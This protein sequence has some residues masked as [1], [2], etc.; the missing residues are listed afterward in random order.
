MGCSPLCPWGPIPVRMCRIGSTVPAKS[1]C[2]LATERQQEEGS[3]A[4]SWCVFSSILEKDK[5]ERSIAVTPRSIKAAMEVLNDREV[6]V[7]T[8]GS[9]R[10]A[11]RGKVLETIT[12]FAI[13]RPHRQVSRVAPACRSLLPSGVKSRAAVAF[14][15]QA[16]VTECY[17]C[18]ANNTHLPSPVLEAGT[19][20]PDV[21]RT[22]PPEASPLG[23]WTAI[24]CPCPRWPP[25]VCGSLCPDLLFPQGH[26]VYWI[27]AHLNGLI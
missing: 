8:G 22:G 11:F 21:G 19:Q 12:L 10:L 13:Q 17:G 5:M 3:P 25:R 23:L 14:A 18:S 7:H 20:D 15:H 4:L 2:D 26:R 16:A 1:R 9:T 6:G 24:S 27:R